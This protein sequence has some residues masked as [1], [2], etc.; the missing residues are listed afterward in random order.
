MSNTEKRKVNLSFTEMSISQ[1]NS[2]LG[3]LKKIRKASFPYGTH[4]LAHFSEKVKRVT[5]TV[6]S[7]SLHMKVK[8]D[9]SAHISLVKESCVTMPNSW[10]RLFRCPEPN[11]I[12]I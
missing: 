9:T 2:K 12:I 6:G 5:H 4:F 1:I 8:H 3:S 10:C 11:A 7:G